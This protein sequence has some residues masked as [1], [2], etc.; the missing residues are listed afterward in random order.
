[1]K[2][3]VGKSF[4][5]ALGVILPALIIQS[6]LIKSTG[7]FIAGLVWSYI[8]A[9]LFAYLSTFRSVGYTIIVTLISFYGITVLRAAHELLLNNEP[10]VTNFFKLLIASTFVS[11][12]LIAICIP[13]WL[14]F[15]LI[16]YLITKKF[17]N[18]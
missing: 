18:Q 5:R 14:V 4:I 6:V 12:A 16:D 9:Y 10:V 1:M 7:F 13:A 15:W 17:G 2:G 8:I 3:N 11:L